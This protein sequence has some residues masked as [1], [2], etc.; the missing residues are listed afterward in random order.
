[1]TEPDRVKTATLDMV[2]DDATR[3]C[4]TRVTPGASLTEEDGLVLVGAIERWI[5]E[6]PALFAVLADGGGGHQADR[7]YRAVLSR[8]FRKR[9]DV[10]RVAFFGLDPVLKVTVEMLQVATGMQLT[11]LENEEAARAWLAGHGFRL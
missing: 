11:V 5:G 6:S 1:M 9:I 7:G 4:V 8:Y 3:V 2:W 10:A